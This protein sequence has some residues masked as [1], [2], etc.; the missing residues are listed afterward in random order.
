VWIANWVCQAWYWVA[1]WVCQAWYWVANW[2]C[3][4]WFWVAKIVC[5]VFLWIVKAVCVVWSWIADLVCVAWDNGRCLG[6]RLFQGQAIPPGPIKHIFVLMLE[7]RSHD[8]PADLCQH[9]G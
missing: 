9:P 4:A 1:N 3:Q 5:T 2:V 6:S 8:Q 7:N